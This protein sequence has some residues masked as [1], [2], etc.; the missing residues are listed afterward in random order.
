[1][2]PTAFAVVAMTPGKVAGATDVMRNFFD[3]I[4]S[5][6]RL[7]EKSSRLA[8]ILQVSSTEGHGEGFIWALR[9][10]RHRG[11]R[12]AHKILLCGPPLSSRFLRAE[13]LMLS[14]GTNQRYGARHPS[15]QM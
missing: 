15:G 11:L 1:L 5:Y 8:A 7:L 4:G 6:E 9:A 2:L 3:A 13:Y 14:A 12:E 10:G